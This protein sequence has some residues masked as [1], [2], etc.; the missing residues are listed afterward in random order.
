MNRLPAGVHIVRVIN[1]LRR[2]REDAERE[3]RTGEDTIAMQKELMER[4]LLDYH[5]PFDQVVEIG[6]GER[7]DTRPVFRQVL[8]DV[9]AGRYNC[10]AVKELSRLTRGDFHDYGLVYELLRSQRI[11]ILTPYRL[12]DPK[13]VNDLRQIRFELFLSREEFETIRE[14]MQG[15]KYVYALSGKFMGSTPA[16]G[17][18]AHPATQ[19]LVISEPEAHVI[20]LIYD[21]YLNGLSN[22][23]MSFRAIATYLTKLQI[24]SPTGRDRWS[25]QTVKAILRNPVYRGEI[26]YSTCT[27]YARKRVPKPPTEWISV[28]NA[29]PAII[30]PNQFEQV[31]QRIESRAAPSTPGNRSTS[32][33]AGLVRC[34]QCNRRMVRHVSSQTYTRKTGERQTIRKE[35]LVCPTSGCTSVSYR[36]VE[37]VLIELLRQLPPS[38]FPKSRAFATS[39]TVLEFSTKVNTAPYS[40]LYLEKRLERLSEQLAVVFRSYE[41]GIYTERDFRERKASLEQ[42]REK[43]EQALRAKHTAESTVCGSSQETQRLTRLAEASATCASLYLSL[44]HS[45]AQNRLLRFFIQEATLEV[46]VKGNRSKRAQLH[47]EVKLKRTPITETLFHE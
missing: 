12:Y 25:A 9:Q 21:L 32:A 7:I 23:E 1:Y 3:R 35:R 4:V 28:P 37:L 26:R 5:L 13:N 17:Y 47:L 8:Q 18:A 11:F 10:I 42:E 31:Q 30:S 34:K 20:R 33:L 16:F 29:H 15:A 44:N 39:R 14:R 19:H 45:P 38:A 24:P 2:S 41:Q 36:Q 6:S 46:L 27:S 40:R 22:K 43:L